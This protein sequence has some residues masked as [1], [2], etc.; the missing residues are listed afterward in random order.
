MGADQRGSGEKPAGRSCG[1]GRGQTSQKLLKS[2]HV[3]A[4]QQSI[5]M[6]QP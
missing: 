3:D 5:V 4:F 2:D 1:S 6:V